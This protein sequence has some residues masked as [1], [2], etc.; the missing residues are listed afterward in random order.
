MD[1]T[2]KSLGIDRLSVAERLRLVE[3]IWET[4][5]DGAEDLEIPQSQRD[6]LDRRIAAAERN[7]QAGRTWEEV[8]ARLAPAETGRSSELLQRAIAEASRLPEPAQDQIAEQILDRIAED[9][10]WDASFARSQDQLARWAKRVREDISEGRVRP[11]SRRR[12]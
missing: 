12:S 5:A 6:E 7:P 4:I 3:E 1:A 9:R 2:V 11:L 8:K 10:A